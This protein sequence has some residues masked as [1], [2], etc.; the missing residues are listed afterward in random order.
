MSADFLAYFVAK[1]GE[2]NGMIVSFL[3]IY[4]CYVCAFL[5]L[6]MPDMLLCLYSFCCIY[7]ATIFRLSRC[8]C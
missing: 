1:K 6:C 8:C 2:K 3:S 5:Q 7:F 4:A